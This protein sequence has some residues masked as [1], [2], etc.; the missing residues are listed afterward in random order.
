M[1]VVGGANAGLVAAL[2]AHEAGALVA[3]LECAPK[4]KRG[5]NSRFANAI[6]RVVHN[7]C[8]NIEP[9][10]YPPTK[11][12]PISH[13]AASSPTPGRPTK[14][15]CCVP[16]R[17]SVTAQ[18]E[19]MFQHSYETVKWMRDRGVKKWQLTLGKFFDENAIAK[20]DIFRPKS[21]QVF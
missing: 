2:S 1:V 14:S 17:T 13:A 16:A 7:G 11:T 8:S 18:M 19:I 9:L 15:T 4:V 10:L 12:K 6:F 3:L 20:G 5:G 21:R